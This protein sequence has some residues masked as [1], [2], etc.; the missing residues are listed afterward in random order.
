[1]GKLNAS[2]DAITLIRLAGVVGLAVLNLHVAQELNCTA[3]DPNR[4]VANR[5]STGLSPMLL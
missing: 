4:I 2:V 5:E 1:M 3:V